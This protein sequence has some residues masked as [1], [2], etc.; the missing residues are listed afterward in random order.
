MVC[1]FDFSSFDDDA[2]SKDWTETE[3]ITDFLFDSSELLLEGSSS[4][5][6]VSRKVLSIGLIRWVITLKLDV[7]W[8]VV[9]CDDDDDEM[10]IGVFIGLEN[11]FVL[12]GTSWLG[13]LLVFVFVSPGGEG[14]DWDGVSDGDDGDEADDDDDDDAEDIDETGDETLAWGTGDEEFCGDLLALLSVWLR[15]VD[16]LFSFSSLIEFFCKRNL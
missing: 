1:S 2:D 3:F 15:F 6:T 12:R 11:P 16:E 14:V 9:D 10:T 4:S 8:F 5:W 7:F 13:L